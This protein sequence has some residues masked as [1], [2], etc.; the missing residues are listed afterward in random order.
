MSNIFDL[1]MREAQSKHGF[2]GPLSEGRLILAEL[3]LKAAAGC[4]ISHTEEA[5]LKSFALLKVNRTPNKKG[6]RFLCDMFYNGS[7]LRPEAYYSMEKHRTHFKDYQPD[8]FKR[9]KK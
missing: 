1:D 4:R 6:F 5:F 8:P 2:N 7:N 3:I 9:E